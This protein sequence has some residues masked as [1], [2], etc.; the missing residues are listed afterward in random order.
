M[1]LRPVMFGCGARMG[2]GPAPEYKLLVLAI[3]V[4]DYYAGG[5]SKGLDAIVSDK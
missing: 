5:P 4:G 3:P 2:L 1:Y